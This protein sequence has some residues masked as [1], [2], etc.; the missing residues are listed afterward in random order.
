MLS[1]IIIVL[2]LIKYSYKQVDSPK[3]IVIIGASF[4]GYHAA[5]LLT[6]SLPTGYR[7][8]VVEKSSHFQFTWVF[9]RFSVVNGHEH[10]AFIPYGP[11]LSGAPK[12]SWLMMQDTVLEVVQN[13][14]FLQSG[15]KLD[16]EY[17][18]IATGSHAGA[19]SRLNVNQKEDGI[20]VLRGLQNRIR[21]ANNLIVVGGGPAGVELSSDAKSLY[22]E[23]NVTLIHSRKTLLNKFGTKLH[24]TAL[25]ALEG[26]GVRVVLGERI[27]PH[28]EGDMHVVLGSG[29]SIPCDLLIRCTGQKA[30]SEII[31]TLCPDS[32]LPVGGFLKVKGTLQ[33]AD[34]RFGNIFAVGDVID[35]PGP[36]NGRSA[37]PLV[38]YNTNL[39]MEGGIELTLGMDK[40]VLYITDGARDILLHSKS[41]DVALKTKSCWKH[42]GAEPFLDDS[43][44]ET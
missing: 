39:L 24:D 12:G 31:A 6:N 2:K 26:L 16:Y 33:I 34:E 17:L 29:E 43:S 15:A 18:V 42:M 36:K 14:I 25:A 4:A 32:L 8:V 10:K 13:A 41:K 27:G 22:P 40:N 3:N 21:D 20:K 7:V 35:S 5:K 38:T 9:P 11:Y 23:K 37:I 30:A 19:P 28:E 44:K 1:G